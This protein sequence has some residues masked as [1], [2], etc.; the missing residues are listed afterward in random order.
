MVDYKDS[1]LKRITVGRLFDADKI[2]GFAWLLE[3]LRKIVRSVPENI[4][5]IE[6]ML[7]DAE[8][9]ALRNSSA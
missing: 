8:R 5:A 7:N 9:R 4:A 1:P 3:Q 2:C 6:E